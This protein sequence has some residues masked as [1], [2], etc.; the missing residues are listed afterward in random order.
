VKGSFLG[1]LSCLNQ[2]GNQYR[3]LSSCL[4][5]ILITKSNNIEGYIGAYLEVI[6]VLEESKKGLV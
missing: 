6:A 4:G 1:A 5:K 3:F 2:F